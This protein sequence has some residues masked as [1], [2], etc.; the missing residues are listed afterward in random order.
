MY[1]YPLTFTFPA[2]TVSPKITAKDASGN[3]ILTAAKKL[4]SSKD[5]IDVTGGGQPLFFGGG[6]V[7]ILT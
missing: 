4:I 3:V 5:E 2:F 6:H 1:N 7:R